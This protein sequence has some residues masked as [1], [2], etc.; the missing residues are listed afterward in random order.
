MRDRPSVGAFGPGRAKLLAG[1]EEPEWV[2]SRV[3]VPG[4]M[5]Q[6]LRKGVIG[7]GFTKSGT[8]G[9]DTEPRRAKPRSGAQLPGR[10]YERAGGNGPM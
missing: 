3:G 2:R 4:P 5:R 1:G 10:A 8:D 7:P 6:G 9:E